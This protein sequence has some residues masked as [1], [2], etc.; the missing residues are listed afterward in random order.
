MNQEKQVVFHKDIKQGIELIDPLPPLVDDN[1]DPEAPSPR[2]SGCP[3]AECS[4]VGECTD[5]YRCESS[6]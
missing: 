6:P 4:R 5:W 2:V 1:T 3:L